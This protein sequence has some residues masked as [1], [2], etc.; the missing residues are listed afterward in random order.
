MHSC[1]CILFFSAFWMLSSVIESG[2]S[3][4]G[5][6]WREISRNCYREC[7]QCTT[8][9]CIMTVHLEHN[10]VYVSYSGVQD[11]T[12]YTNFYDRQ[13]QRIGWFVWDI[14][15][16]VYV[17]RCGPWQKAKFVVDEEHQRNTI[18]WREWKIV[19]NSTSFFLF[20]NRELVYELEFK[21]AG[22]DCSTTWAGDKVGGVAFSGLNG[23][24]W[25]TEYEE[26]DPT[27][28]TDFVTTVRPLTNSYTVVIG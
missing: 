6:Q 21:R 25:K 26:I 12:R 15:L 11:T 27:T 9:D 10:P 28:E 23:A 24:R 8:V 18:Y 14:R 17:H 19:K 22:S 16:G 13:G 1:F 20:L 5:G 2:K 4:N 3:K 7:K